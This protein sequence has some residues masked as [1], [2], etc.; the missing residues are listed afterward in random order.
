MILAKI[1]MIGGIFASIFQK[2]IDWITGFFAWIPQLIY[3]L[4]TSAAS[5]LDLLQFIIRKLAGLDV[6]YVDGQEVTGDIVSGFVRGI[7]GIDKNPTYSSLS[8]VFWSMVIFGAI[9]LVT[10][11][12]FAIIKAHYNYDAAK[13]NPFHIIGQSFKSLCLMA[14]VPIVAVFG[15]FFC[16]VVLQ[17]LDQVTSYDSAM[18]GVFESNALSKLE[19]GKVKGTEDRFAYTSYDFFGAG[20]FTNST[21]FSGALFKVAAYDC[22]RVRLGVYRTP[23]SEG[24]DGGWTNFGIFYAD[25]E[26]A[27]DKVAEQIDYAFANNLTL[28]NRRRASIAGGD[29]WVLS[30][31]LTVG[32]SAVCA[33][34]LVSVK[35][36]SKYNVGLVWYFYNLWAFNWFIAFAGII[37]FLSILSNVVFGLM[38]RMIQLLALFFV[39]PP[40]IGIAPLDG[41]GAFTKWRQQYTSDL[42]M[43]FGAVVGMNLFFIILPFLNTI[44]F[45]NS[46]FLDSIMNVVI[47]LAALTMVKNFIGMLSGFIGASDANKVG[48]ETKG[49]VGQLAQKAGGATLKAATIGVKAFKAGGGGLAGRAIGKGVGKIGSAITN[50]QAKNAAI[51][52]ALGLGDEE[53]NPSR[54]NKAALT[55]LVGEKKANKML[56]AVDDNKNLASYRKQIA[57]ANKL[58]DPEKRQERIDAI[59]K[60]FENKD[61]TNIVRM[62]KSQDVKKSLGRAAAVGFSAFFG[63]GKVERGEDGKIDAGA[64]FKAAGGAILDVGSAAIKFQF[65]DLLGGSKLAKTLKKKD[66]GVGDAFRG[67]VGNF[68][69]VGEKING[70]KVMQTEK[71][72]EDTKEKND[73]SDS[74]AIRDTSTN[75]KAMLDAIN[76]LV[77]KL[78]S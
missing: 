36:F 40:L 75:T 63:G 35:R 76:T 55:A 49:S 58:K 29:S 62:A 67:F 59:N 70:S 64:T 66:S 65:G 38:V 2:I 10:T 78:G 34:G 61:G 31:S 51:K 43:A 18:S 69:A 13:S 71:S 8:T 1:S 50:H 14:I 12:I 17:A 41:G 37:V 24:D 60:K 77:N 44:S 7:L 15:V 54:R 56:K 23:H 47:M 5:V 39:F 4:Y 6:Y 32:Y 20:A 57:T 53:G 45:F 19:K 52:K 46:G 74:A 11:T 33:L 22:N 16:N 9:L 3:F 25:G 30:S 42:L 21:T 26:G 73:A 48:E 68:G 28:I 27:R 72:K